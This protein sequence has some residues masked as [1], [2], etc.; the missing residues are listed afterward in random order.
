MVLM[1]AGKQIIVNSRP[2]ERLYIKR[3]QNKKSKGHLAQ[4]KKTPAGPAAAARDTRGIGFTH[5]LG[6]GRISLKESSDAFCLLSS[7]PSDRI[8]LCRFYPH[9]RKLK[10][11][12][13]GFLEDTQDSWRTPRTQFHS[14]QAHW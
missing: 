7:F 13:P 14:Q 9:W 1:P 2:T 6:W 4:L 8:S 10:E 3:V 5:P 11:I 12:E